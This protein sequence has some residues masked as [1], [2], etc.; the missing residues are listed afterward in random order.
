M[1][2]KVPLVFMADS[3]SHC[4]PKPPTQPA[5]TTSEHLSARPSQ[6]ESERQELRSLHTSHASGDTVA[7]PLRR[8]SPAG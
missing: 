6:L 4:L 8:A 1:L 7:G 3:Q 5:Q 2:P